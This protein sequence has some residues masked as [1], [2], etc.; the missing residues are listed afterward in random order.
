MRYRDMRWPCDYPVTVLRGSTRSRATIIN[1]STAGLRL[2]L[3]SALPVGEVVTF[4]LGNRMVA[5]TVR[6]CREGLAGLR[7]LTPLA[8]QDVAAIRHGRGYA[9]TVTAGHWNSHLRELR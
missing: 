1:V 8:R 7:L 9:D 4:D 5:A 6:W 3:E 2:R